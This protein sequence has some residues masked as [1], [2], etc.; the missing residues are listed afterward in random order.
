V[1]RTSPLIVGAGPAGCAAAIGLARDG[2]SVTLVDRDATVRDALCGGFL[3]WRTIPQLRNLGLDPARLGA[4][5]VTQLAL[6]AGGREVQVDLP[7]RSFGLSRRALDTELRRLAIAAGAELA[8]DHIRSIEATTVIGQSRM[9]HGDSLFLATGKHD[10]RGLPRP[11][12]SAD[13]ALGLRLRLPRLAARNRLLAGRIELHLFDR[14]YAGIVLQEDG[15]ANVCLAVRKSRLTAAGGAPAE[16]V[17]ALA[18]HHPAL[19]ARLDGFA[20][21]PI[22]T[23]GSVPYGWIAPRTKPGL[24][25]LGDQAAVIPSLAGEGI[26][27]ALTSG[28]LAARHWLKLGAHGA[29]EYQRAMAARAQRPVRAARVAWELAERPRVA[30]AGLALARHF[31]PAVRA[32]MALS[33][34]APDPALA[35]RSS[36]A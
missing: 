19:A 35:P 17:A 33:R 24:Y 4:H 31:P 1:R 3:S 34:I 25:R 6:F 2:E 23:I 29:E 27:I 20:G 30:A 28:A 15:S 8:I 12:S 32:L 36:P 13:P 22:E 5:P 16:L 9:W 11:R 10:M 7:A 18:Q 26:S 21:T 14:G